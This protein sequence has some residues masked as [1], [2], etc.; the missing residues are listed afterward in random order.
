MSNIAVIASAGKYYVQ[1]YQ[2]FCIGTMREQS[3]HKFQNV[4]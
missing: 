2:T 4:R 3:E 1:K